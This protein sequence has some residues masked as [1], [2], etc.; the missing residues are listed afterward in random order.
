MVIDNTASI[1][2]L[3]SPIEPPYTPCGRPPPY[4]EQ[5][6]R[7]AY[8]VRHTNPY[9]IYIGTWIGS[10]LPG[11]K[12]NAVYALRDS[13]GR[14]HRRISMTNHAGLIVWG[15][16]YK[17]QYTAC[18]HKDVDYCTSYEGMT[19]EEV[20]TDLALRFEVVWNRTRSLSGFPYSCQA[21]P[22]SST[23]ESDG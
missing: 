22:T 1:P 4:P 11:M 5:A 12:S 15:G 20:D 2:C 21:S 6:Y 3:C 9:G 19:K 7:L 18:S 23:Y 14:I 16:N 8:Y 13:K 17:A 10:G